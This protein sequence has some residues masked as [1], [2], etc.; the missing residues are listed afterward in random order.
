MLLRV[1]YEFSASHGQDIFQVFA[2][3]VFAAN[4][5]L[6]KGRGKW[7]FLL[8]LCL[9]A[10]LPRQKVRAVVGPT[11]CLVNSEMNGLSPIPT[12]HADCCFDINF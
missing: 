12:K 11:V 9:V 10:G 7:E 5:K 3:A 2:Y 6:E 1:I 8:V 4:G